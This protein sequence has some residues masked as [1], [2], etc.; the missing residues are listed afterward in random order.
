MLSPPKL[1]TFMVRIKHKP[2]PVYSQLGKLRYYF[3]NSSFQIIG[4]DNGFV[5][6]SELQPSELSSCYHIKIEYRLGKHPDVYVIDPYPLL[7]ANGKTKL[8]HVYDHD[9]QR[10]CLY[11]KPGEEWAA[12][13][14]IADT[15]IPWTS[16]WLLHYEFWVLTGEW[17]GGGIH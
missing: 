6:K 15:I 2:I 12:S 5:W 14:M 10:L 16:E 8:P 4:C 9:K 3:P 7:L 1:I 13:K 11:F 17:R